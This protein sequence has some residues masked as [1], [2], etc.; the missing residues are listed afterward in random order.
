MSSKTQFGGQ[1][2]WFW[3]LIPYKEDLHVCETM[4]EH[5]KPKSTS[6]YWIGSENFHTSLV[7]VL[8]S[9]ADFWPVIYLILRLI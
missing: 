5:K 1:K 2:I 9:N 6:S 8:G 7:L 3:P 4:A